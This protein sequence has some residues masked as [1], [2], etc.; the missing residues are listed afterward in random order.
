MTTWRRSSHSGTGQQSDCVEVAGLSGNVGVRDSKHP[1]G[2]HLTLTATS[3]RQ[4][5]TNIKRGT[6]DLP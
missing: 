6:H 1:N 2:P 5:A 4:L 3:F